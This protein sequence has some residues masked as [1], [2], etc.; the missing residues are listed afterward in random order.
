MNLPVLY[1]RYQ[2]ILAAISSNRTFEG[3][4]LFLRGEKSRYIQEESLPQIETLFPNY[5]LETIP[6]AGHW[7]HADQPDALLAQLTGF[8]SGE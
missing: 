1:D 3:P 8:L 2:D 7:I 5:Q 4:T 6:G